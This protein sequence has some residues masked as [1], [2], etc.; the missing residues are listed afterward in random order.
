MSSKY[1]LQCT[2]NSKYS[3]LEIY[4]SKMLHSLDVFLST[5]T[6]KYSLCHCPKR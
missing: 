3:L 5:T 2:H 4:S 6:E 1:E